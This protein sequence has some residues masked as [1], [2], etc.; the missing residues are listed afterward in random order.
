MNVGNKPHFTLPSKALN[1]E[2]SSDNNSIYY[3]LS[4]RQYCQVDLNE[5]KIAYESPIL[6]EDKLSFIK[7][8]DGIIITA[9]HDH[10]VKLFDVRSHS[11]V[12]TFK[13]IKI[14]YHRNTWRV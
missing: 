12:H 6:H 9:S 3:G 13:S 10:T 11:H 4:S 7:E 2:V 8:K 14:K 5:G 1:S